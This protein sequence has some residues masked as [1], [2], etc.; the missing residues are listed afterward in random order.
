[1]FLRDLLV[2]SVAF[3]LGLSMIQVALLNRGWCF[4]NFIVRRIE[5]SVGR[6]AARKSLCFGGAA[7]ILLGAWTMASPWL[8]KDEA[9]ANLRN[10]MLTNI[11][12]EITV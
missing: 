11:R 8:K 10:G 6:A 9:E 7:L 2:A 1:M 12:H 5:S 3:G 4:E